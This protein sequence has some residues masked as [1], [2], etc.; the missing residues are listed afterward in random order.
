MK[1]SLVAVLAQAL[2]AHALDKH[3]GWNGYGLAPG[4]DCPGELHSFC[5]GVYC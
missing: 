3:C 2:V 5:D 4:E 1:F